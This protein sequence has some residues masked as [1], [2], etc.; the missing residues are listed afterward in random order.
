MPIGPHFLYSR[1]SSLFRFS[2]G[3]KNVSI[4]LCLI[5]LSVISPTNAQTSGEVDQTILEILVRIDAK[6]NLAEKMLTEMPNQASNEVAN[7][8]REFDSSFAARVQE[9]IDLHYNEVGDTL[10]NIA[11]PAE[12]GNLELVWEQVKA[13]TYDSSV[14]DRLVEDFIEKTDRQLE[15]RREE[16]TQFIETELATFLTQRLHGAQENIWKPYS[17]IPGR[18][19]PALDLPS[20]PAPVLSRLP[21]PSPDDPT[22]HRGFTVVIGT[23]LLLRGV[24]QKLADQIPRKVKRTIRKKLLGKVASKG[25]PFLGVALLVVEAWDASQA[26]IELERQ[27]RDGYLE[28]YKT[29]FTANS[30]LYE[31][32][33]D[34]EPTVR[35]GIEKVVDENLEGWTRHC[36]IEVRRLLDAS[37]VASF[38]PNVKAYIQDQTR[39]GRDTGEIIEE[40]LS[41]QFAYPLNVIREISFRKLLVIR[42]SGKILDDAEFRHLASQLG[43]HLVRE[44]AQHRE[45]IFLAAKTLGVNVFLDVLRGS[46]DIDWFQIRTAF[47]DYPPNMSKLSRQG[48]VRA[49]NNGVAQENVP[50]NT[51]ENIETH[52]ELFDKIVPILGS[53]RRKIYRLFGASSLIEVVSDALEEIPGAAPSF[54]THWEVQDWRRYRIRAD[55]DALLVVTKH[56]LKEKEQ[57][58]VDLAREL[59][60]ERDEL[61]SI[62]RDVG[63]CGLHLWDAYVDGSAGRKQRRDAIE[64]IQ[65]YR[66][67]YPCDAL[68]DRGDLEYAKL[69]D[70]LPFGVGVYAF[71][72]IGPD[73][74][75]FIAIAVGILLVLIVIGWRRT[76][77]ENL[78]A[79]SAQRSG[80]SSDEAAPELQESMRS[81]VQAKRPEVN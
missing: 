15:P 36:R 71:R 79:N 22:S 7:I 67:G 19:F 80:P 47:E 37:E 1:L 48:L 53:D 5:L 29:E 58:A 70:S 78:Q 18:Y 12:V 68:L 42:R 64:A 24:R 54:L 33:F 46:E 49:I 4:A 32:H 10:R 26:R 63:V 40:L 62:V 59:S 50:T 8:M 14:L 76:R 38:S 25:I 56:R 34:G 16:L 13:G 81:V 77:K 9:R 61:I 41:V 20:L 2:W 60:G 57:H 27:L 17:E 52:A 43:L 21:T 45:E 6:R 3:R 30:I 51:L 66:K 65:L 73:S 44:F 39:G 28:S 31:L 35:S 72:R 55:F 11:L 74:N 75:L 23:A 69:Y